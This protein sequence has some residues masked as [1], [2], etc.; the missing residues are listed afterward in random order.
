[1]MEELRPLV[2]APPVLVPVMAAAEEVG[3]GPTLEQMREL[4]RAVAA[5]SAPVVASAREPGSARAPGL[6]ALLRQPAGL[7]QAV[8]LREILD[9]PPGLRPPA[10]PGQGIWTRI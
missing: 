6:L 2:V 1:M 8:L 4:Q 3:E 10:T 9:A 7:R 5:A